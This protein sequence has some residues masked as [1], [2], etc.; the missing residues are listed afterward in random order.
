MVIGIEGSIHLVI[1]ETS[2]RVLYVNP[3]PESM[4]R[5]V[6]TQDKIVNAM[7]FIAFGIIVLL[8]VVFVLVK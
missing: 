6:S 8:A 7:P 4:Q 5:K 2:H 3:V 1:E